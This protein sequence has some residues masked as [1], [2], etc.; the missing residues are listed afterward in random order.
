[1]NVQKLVSKIAD[2]SNEPVGT[3]AKVV[4]RLLIKLAC[5]PIVEVAEMLADYRDLA[6]DSEPAAPIA[7]EKPAGA[8]KTAKKVKQ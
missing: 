8:R 6:E 5:Y 4:R 7:E 1:M 2:Q 3:V